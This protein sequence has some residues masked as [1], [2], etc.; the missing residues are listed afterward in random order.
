MFSG[1]ANPQAFILCH[2]LCRFLQVS[3]LCCKFRQSS[4]YLL[5]TTRRGR[6]TS[7]ACPTA[8]RLWPRLWACLRPSWSSGRAGGG[9]GPSGWPERGE[10]NAPLVGWAWAGG[11]GHLLLLDRLT[12][13]LPRKKRINGNCLPAVLTCGVCQLQVGNRP[14]QL[15]VLFP[16][17]HCSMGM[18]GDFEQAVEMGSTNVRVGSTIFGARVYK[19]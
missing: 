2:S 7:S 9:E 14:N 19:S 10:G 1:Q 16:V 18:S 12:N 4:G 17:A 6:R 5:Q 11:G 15:A 8:A 13:R 3:W